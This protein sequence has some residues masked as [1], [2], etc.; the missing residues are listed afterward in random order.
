MPKEIKKITLI[1]LDP[2]LPD[3]F[4]DTHPLPRYG[5]VAIGT[6]LRNAGYDVK[7]FVEHFAPVSWERV[8]DSDAVCFFAITSSLS[9]T[10]RLAREI[11]N[12]K[13]IPLI[14]GGTA[15]CYTVDA[16]LEYF[17]FVVRNEGDET[18]LE[19][20]DAIQQKRSPADILG[21]SYKQNGQVINNAD[22]GPVKK[23]INADFS[24]IEGFDKRPKTCPRFLLNF[25]QFSR[26]C[27]YKCRFC[28]VKKMFGDGYRTKSIDD[29]MD[30]LKNMRKRWFYFFIVD[31]N[32]FADK[33]K[34]K[35]LLRRIIKEKLNAKFVAY[36]ALDVASD[37]ELLKLCKKAGIK[38]FIIGI[39]SFN[40]EV[41]K[42]IGK[43]Q[44]RAQILKAVQTITAHGIGISG[45]FVV[46]SDSESKGSIREIIELANKYG[47]FHICLFILTLFDSEYTKFPAPTD[48][49]RIHYD[50]DYSNGCYS[51]IF[52][53]TMK[54]SELQYEVLR[55][56]KNF[57]SV[58][59]MLIR[60][61]TGRLESVFYMLMYR[62]SM[63]R[64]FNEMEKYIEYLKF[65][66]EGMYDENNRL[67][68][69]KLPKIS[70][71]P[72]L[73]EQNKKK[74]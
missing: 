44:S 60:I 71:S 70:V 66:E 30:E 16:A 19:V 42:A 4:S 56:Y 31:N 2:R 6:I 51:C 52:P 13:N 25:V 37:I 48:I 10:F 35:E 69:S 1:H 46:G 20:F 62:Y 26:G 39:E 12:K 18:I 9:K 8:L 27:P 64:L 34:T 67:I 38:L 22:R 59:Q 15:V 74:L 24:L 23:L 3:Y 11:K 41:L 32:F 36:A 65:A 54:P 47:F 72:V 21:I 63:R 40:D 5:F 58:K 49:R 45:S 7:I 53:K 55:G 68:E 17:D 43:K 33:E 14:V 28:I 61:F 29:M 73:F 50:F 57:L